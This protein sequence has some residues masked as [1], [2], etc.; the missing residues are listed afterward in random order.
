MQAIERGLQILPE[1]V[2][3]PLD[4]RAGATDQHIIPALPPL[5]RQDLRRRRARLR[6]TALPTL[7]EQ[8]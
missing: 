3:G 8:V 4:R 6:V 1:Q 7:R 2:E 5:A